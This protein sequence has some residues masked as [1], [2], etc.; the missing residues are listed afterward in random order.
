MADMI[1][2][3]SLKCLGTTTWQNLSIYLSI[4]PYCTTATKYAPPGFRGWLGWVQAIWRSWGRWHWKQRTTSRT[5]K[6][7]IRVMTRR[8]MKSLQTLDKLEPWR[9]NNNLVMWRTFTCMRWL[10]LHAANDCCPILWCTC[11]AFSKSIRFCLMQN[12]YNFEFNFVYSWWK[13][14]F[15][16]WF[17]FFFVFSLLL[18]HFGTI[19]TLNFSVSL[20]QFR[21][22][23]FKRPVR[24]LNSYP[25]FQLHHVP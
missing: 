18:L 23:H 10:I 6:H 17:F 16:W 5:M 4:P 22:K 9:K 11:W 12:L 19:G 7:P 24:L 14:I 8:R 15:R 2:V 21:N 20:V 3:C 13:Q 1:E 25:D